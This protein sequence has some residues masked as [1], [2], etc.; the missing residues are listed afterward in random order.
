MAKQLG[1]AGGIADSLE[2]IVMI[3]DHHKHGCFSKSGRDDETLGSILQVI[4]SLLRVLRGLYNLLG[5]SITPFDVDGILFL[6][7]G[8]GLSTDDR[9]LVLSLDCTIEFATGGLILEHVDLHHCVSGA[10]GTAQ[11]VAV[12]QIGRSREPKLSHFKM[13]HQESLKETNCFSAD[14]PCL[15]GLCPG[16]PAIS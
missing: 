12:S 2:G 3:H 7:D 9:F 4:A 8:D 1:G 10:A 5:T 6:E 14:L 11:Q 15:K 16:K 13:L